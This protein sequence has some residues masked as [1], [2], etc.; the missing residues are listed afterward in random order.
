LVFFFEKIVER[1]LHEGRE[2][3]SADVDDF[4]GA[5]VDDRRERFLYC[6]HDGSAAVVD[7]AFTW[8]HEAGGEKQTGH[9][10][11]EYHHVILSDSI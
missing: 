6:F 10:H 11:R 5:D 1:G 4:R 8:R 3:G 2:W 7:G 9:N